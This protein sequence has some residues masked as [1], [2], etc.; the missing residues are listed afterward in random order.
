MTTGLIMYNIL[1][2]YAISMEFLLLRHRCLSCETPLQVRRDNV[3]LTVT[4]R[5]V[6]MT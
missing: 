2:S 3:A 6:A 4:T 1:L 5:C